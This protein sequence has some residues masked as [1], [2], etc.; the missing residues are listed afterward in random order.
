MDDA[1]QVALAVTAIVAAKWLIGWW[2]HSRK[3]R[4]FRHVGSVSALIYYPVKSCKGIPLQ[5]AKA[6]VKGLF[7]DDVTDR[8]VKSC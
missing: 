7:F 8:Y 1:K 6:A 2:L 3:R 5:S 4:Q